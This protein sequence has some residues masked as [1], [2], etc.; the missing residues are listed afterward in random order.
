MS[1]RSFMSQTDAQFMQGGARTSIN[2][3]QSW[4]VMHFLLHDPR[5]AKKGRKV[6]REYFTKLKEGSTKDEAF[7]ETFGK[8]DLLKLDAAWKSYIRSL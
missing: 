5:V 2:Y 1:L 6:I 7:K 3:A 8:L 4:A